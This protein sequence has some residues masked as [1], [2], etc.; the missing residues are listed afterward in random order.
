MKKAMISQPMNGFSDEEILSN[1]DKAIS[2][3]KEKGYEIENTFFCDNWENDDGVKDA[4]V[5]G[6]I[7]IP[8]CVLGNSI[9]RMSYCDAVY[10]CKGW[11]KARRC[12][13]EHDVAS[14]YGLE[15]MYE[16]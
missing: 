9:V 13:I 7:Y 5:A 15:I 12:K 6:F 3:L 8:V 10:F 14:A 4:G 11:E 16:E 2:I 1:K